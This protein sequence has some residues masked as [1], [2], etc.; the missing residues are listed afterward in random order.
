MFDYETLL[1]KGAFEGQ[2]SNHDSLTKVVRDLGSRETSPMNM[3]FPKSPGSK[4]A[5]TKNSSKT[6]GFNIMLKPLMPTL[7]EESPQTASP[8]INLDQVDKSIHVNEF[9]E[10]TPND[11]TD[12]ELHELPEMSKL[13]LSYKATPLGDSEFDTQPQE[14]VN[15]TRERGLTE[16]S[17][18]VPRA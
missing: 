14:K 7:E 8:D 16:T 2:S 1:K 3:N 17:L 5:T 12:V 11:V 6:S 18:N 15:K 4:P 10:P 13:D 9:L